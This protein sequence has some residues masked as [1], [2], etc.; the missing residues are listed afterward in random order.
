MR[1]DNNRREDARHVHRHPLPG[2]GRPGHRCARRGGA[3]RAVRRARP[4]KNVR[5]SPD[6][7]HVSVFRAEPRADSREGRAA[8]SILLVRGLRAREH[9]EAVESGEARERL[10]RGAGAARSGRQGVGRPCEE[11]GPRLHLS[12]R[13]AEVPQRRVARAV[14][15]RRHR[16]QLR[17]RRPH[18]VD[19]DARG[20]R[21]ARERRRIGELHR[22]DD[23][24]AVAHGVAGGDQAAG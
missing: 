22:G 1:R 14:D 3:S 9:A 7:S 6:D 23:G 13:G 16:V 18:A 17:R 8:L 24:S 2:P 12:Q 10:D 5:G 11:D 20:L 15:V 19:R 21:A 4:R